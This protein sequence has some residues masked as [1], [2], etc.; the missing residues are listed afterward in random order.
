LSFRIAG[1]NRKP[2]AYVEPFAVLWDGW[3]GLP[4]IN[5]RYVVR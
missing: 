4:A 5:L 1:N 2:G 3:R